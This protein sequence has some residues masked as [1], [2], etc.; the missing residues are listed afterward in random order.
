M[1][2]FGFFTEEEMAT[3]K[4]LITV[5][6]IGAKTAIGILGHVTPERFAYAVSI[7]DVKAIRAPGV[8]PK[9]AARIVLELTDKIAKEADCAIFYTHHHAKGEQGTKKAMDRGSGS[10]VFSRDADLMIDLTA[11]EIDGQTK[12]AL[13]NNAMCDYWKAKLDETGQDW[14]SRCSPSDIKSSGSLAALYQAVVGVDPSK[15][16][17]MVMNEQQ[18]FET[19]LE[20]TKAFRMEFV[21]RS[22]E[23]PEPQNVTFRHPIH[24]LDRSGALVMAEPESYQFGQRKKDTASIKEQKLDVFVETVDQLIISSAEGHTT[25]AEIAEALEIDARTVTR[26]LNTLT[27]RYVVE[28]DG[29]GRGAVAKVRFLT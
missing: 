25:Y 29:T 26:R 5:S 23:T 9:I 19:E 12:A 13:L 7:G 22:F 3:F 8:G 20:K 28:K 6:G 24:R 10:G 17:I 18:H 14:R 11:L 15:I 2:I 27:E 21:V 4:L 1:E 16:T